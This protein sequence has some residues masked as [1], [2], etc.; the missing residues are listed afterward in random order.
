MSTEDLEK[1]LKFLEMLNRYEKP[2]LKIFT[3]LELRLLLDYERRKE[4]GMLCSHDEEHIQGIWAAA[5]ERNQDQREMYVPSTTEE[6]IAR[7]QK[8]KGLLIKLDLIKEPHNGWFPQS[9][10]MI[11]IAERVFRGEA[12]KCEFERLKNLVEEFENRGANGTTK[13]MA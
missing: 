12:C 6:C 1:R 8:L 5:I 10:R 7:D 4:A 2:D 3:T 9:S 13:K 11:Y